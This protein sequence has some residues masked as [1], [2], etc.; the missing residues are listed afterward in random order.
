M[1]GCAELAS[2]APLEIY[3]P[4]P[5]FGISVCIAMNRAKS[6]VSL[7]DHAVSAIADNL[8]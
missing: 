8:G 3:F 1:R 5:A 4:N 7:G 6:F 2:F